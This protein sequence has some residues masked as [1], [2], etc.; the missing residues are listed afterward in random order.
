MNIVSGSRFWLLPWKVGPGDLEGVQILQGIGNWTATW[1][2][3]LLL[4]GAPQ[5]PMLYTE[6]QSIRYINYK[7][8]KLIYC[9]F[10]KPYSLF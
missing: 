2:K 4:Q 7:C 8:Y 1:R 6:V 9:S 5:L 3:P 10:Y